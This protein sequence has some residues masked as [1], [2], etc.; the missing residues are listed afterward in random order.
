[1]EYD[2]FDGV[3][4]DRGVFC[5]QT[6]HEFAK[7]RQSRHLRPIGNTTN[8]PR[9]I[10]RSAYA[11][12]W[13]T[14]SEY[15]HTKISIWRLL[16]HPYKC[17]IPFS[18][19]K[20]DQQ[21]PIQLSPLC[22]YLLTQ[23]PAWLSILLQTAGLELHLLTSIQGCRSSTTRV[24]LRKQTRINVRLLILLLATTFSLSLSAWWTH[25]GH[26]GQ[27]SWPN[28]T[29]LQEFQ[30]EIN[31]ARLVFES[32][33]FYSFN[34]YISKSLK[35]VHSFYQCNTGRLSKEVTH[36]PLTLH[37]L[38]RRLMQIGEQD[39]TVLRLFLYRKQLSRQFCQII[40]IL[41]IRLFGRWRR[42]GSS[43]HFKGS[44]LLCCKVAMISPVSFIFFSVKI[45][46]VGDPV[47]PAVVGKGKI[48]EFG[49]CIVINVDSRLDW[50][51]SANNI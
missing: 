11:C 48:G 3:L 44:F 17:S 32:K 34:T 27:W 31:E 49:I 14:V 19:S 25:S 47:V 23:T 42:C 7:P 46:F 50:T 13:I 22:M 5:L 10:L 4:S 16:K 28:R 35:F 45:D 21:L 37:Q 51:E 33:L 8:P 12:W 40:S 6:P 1:M 15:L 2:S 26:P 38:Q 41:L 9:K 39:E 18:Q 43:S 36:T 29:S 20:F 24:I 30:R